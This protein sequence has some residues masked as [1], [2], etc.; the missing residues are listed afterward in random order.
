MALSAVLTNQDQ[1]QMLL[2]YYWC[3]PDCTRKHF[4]NLI[5]HQVLLIKAVP[6][7]WPNCAT[8]I[9]GWNG[10]RWFWFGFYLIH[11]IGPQRIYTEG[12]ACSDV[13]LYCQQCTTCQQAKL[14]N[15]VQVPL[16]NIP[17]GKPWEMLAADIL[18][19]PVSRN[20]HCYLL[21][22]MDYFTKWVE[23]VP[24][25]NQTAATVTICEIRLSSR[26]VVYLAFLLFCILIKGTIS[27][28]TC[29]SKCYKPLGYRNLVLQH[30]THNVMEWWNRFNNSLL[31]M[32]RCYVNSEEDWE[33]YLPLV[34]YAY[35]TAPHSTTGVSSF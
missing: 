5:T 33:T 23:A 24:L 7:H 29:F 9:L 14:S 21:V 31:Q 19:V 18:E 11:G 35:H 30:T 12:I 25:Q 28:V 26:Y 32:L 6:R 20:N 4:N 2:R 15:P 34:L 22:V 16:C 3:Q 10:K 13:Q 27:R 1:H 17:I 8:G